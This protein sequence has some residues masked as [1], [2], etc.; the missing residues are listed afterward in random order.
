MLAHVCDV[1]ACEN[2]SGKQKLFSNSVSV[3]AFLDETDISLEEIK[4]RQNAAL[5]SISSSS[6]SSSSSSSASCCSKDDLGGRGFHILPVS[7]D[8]ALIEPRNPASSC[9]PSPISN[10]MAE[11]ERMTLREHP[12]GSEQEGAELSSASSDEYFLAQESMEEEEQ[13]ART[14]LGSNSERLLCSR[15]R[16]WDHTSSASSS[17]SGSYRSLERSNDLILTTPPRIRKGLF[18]EG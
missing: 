16:S 8:S 11:F 4:N 2:V 12:V 7:Q 9:P 6:A 15:S 1:C 18:I 13:R 14:R 17:T 3:G 10:L 5:T